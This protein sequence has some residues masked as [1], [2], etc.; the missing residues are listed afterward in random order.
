MVE[1]FFNAT[2]QNNDNVEKESLARD[3]IGFGLVLGFKTRTLRLGLE[4]SGLKD[5]GSE[6][7]S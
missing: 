4:D 2:L 3:E 5:S 6:L 7:N 1:L